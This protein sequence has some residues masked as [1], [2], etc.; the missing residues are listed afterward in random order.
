M[1]FKLRALGIIRLG[2]REGE[3]WAWL[4]VEPSA[5]TA[6]QPRC[7]QICAKAKVMTVVQV[8]PWKTDEGVR[9]AI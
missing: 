6:A 9:D 7:G 3:E 5:I 1:H 4:L 2:Y 8:V